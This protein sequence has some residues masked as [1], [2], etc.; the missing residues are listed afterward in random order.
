MQKNTCVVTLGAS[1]PLGPSRP[2]S[3]PVFLCVDYSVPANPHSDSSD[4]YALAGVPVAFPA[5]PFISQGFL[6]GRL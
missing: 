6:P 3:L 5:L 2:L 1:A 4:F